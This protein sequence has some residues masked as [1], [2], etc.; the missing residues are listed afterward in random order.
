MQSKKMTPESPLYL[1]QFLQE[2]WLNSPYF[3]PFF[4]LRP[5]RK[6][7]AEKIKAKKLSFSNPKKTFCAKFQV[8]CVN[9]QVFSKLTKDI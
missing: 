1:A 8:S 9:L 2:I 5:N 6:Y 7:F 3:G 4:I